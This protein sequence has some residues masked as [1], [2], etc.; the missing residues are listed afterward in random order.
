MNA[1]IA[2]CCN[3]P[4]NGCFT[5]FVSA[6]Q[7]GDLELMS[8]RW[9]LSKPG[10]RLRIK[11]GRFTLAGKAWPFVASKSYYGNWCWDAYWVEPEVCADFLI[12][13]HG[14]QLFDVDCAETRVFNLWRGDGPLLS[15]RDFLAR[16]FGKPSTYA[17]AA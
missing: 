8:R 12:W 1:R 13:L 10:P 16:Y 2:F 3:D 14:R 17:A 9:W 11:D 15:H 6:I 7:V 4:D 5:G